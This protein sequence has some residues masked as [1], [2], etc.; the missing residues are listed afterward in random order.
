MCW[1]FA[2]KWKRPDAYNILMQWLQRLEYRW[3]D[4]AW[5]VVGNET[6]KVKYVKAVG[7]VSALMD[8]V[9]YNFDSTTSFNYGIA[10]TRWATHW[11][12]TEY[13]TH[14]HYD[15]K[16]RIFLVHN[17]I[18]ENM[19]KLKSYLEKKWYK[20]YSD[21]DSEVIAKLIEDNWTWD[22]LH[23]VESVLPLIDGA[24]AFLIISK[25]E[26]S[27]MIWLKYGSP[28]VFGYNDKWE[29]FFAS[30][31]NALVWK[32]ENIIYLDDWDLIY[33]NWNDYMIK[34]EGKLISKPIEKIDTTNL[35]IDKGKFEHFMLKEIHEQPEVLQRVF[36]WR[37]NFEKNSL[38]A[39]AFQEMDEFKFDR[40][41]F[42]GCW[43]SYNAW[44][45]GTYWFED[46]AG[47]EARAD[48]A[49]EYEYRNIKVDEKTLYIFVSQSWETADSIE[50][51]NIIKNKG[52]KTLG[53]VNVVGSTI[54]RL[55][56][57][58]F[59]S[60][61][62][63]EVGVAS[64]K[65][66]ISQIATIML[67]VIYFARKRWMNQAQ[68]EKLSHELS[69]LENLVQKILDNEDH[70][71]DIAKWL[72]KYWNFFFVWKHYQMPIALESSLKFK[73]I[74]YIHSEAYPAWELKHG[75]LALIDTEFPTIFLLP[76][77]LLYEK[78]I[79]SFKEI[80]AR[81]GKVVV[82]SNKEI[83]GADWLIKIPETIPELYPVLTAVVWQL[84]AYYMAKQ[85]GRDIDKPRNLAK[86]VTVK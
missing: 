73:E 64:T 15:S 27:D 31:V 69:C 66:F 67:I 13:N 34:S 18:I 71:K 6:W 81:N 36:K 33:I 17:G 9:L 16:K 68:F 30:D 79:S 12:V 11:W 24:Y 42:I 83:A 5:L 52:W 43:T 25:D 57:F 10:H 77:D 4:S 61:A 29:M 19:D 59:F 65:A 51:L 74:S 72:K 46:L 14:P 28:L 82:V 70:I 37:I 21:T 50:C 63:V 78:N 49:S 2:Y 76:R 48:I 75:P 45:L 85:L 22:L 60:R 84:L 3:Y 1:I 40:I 55:T 44:L 32:V 56:D 8:K 86:S 35:D 23:S 38:H 54:S 47:M 7:K 80:K 26:P 62:G 41:Q 58:W 20:F 39:A 53:I